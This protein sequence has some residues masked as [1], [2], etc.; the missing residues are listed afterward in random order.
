MEEGLP[1]RIPMILM[2]SVLV[3]E[4]IDTPDPVPLVPPCPS[5]RLCP[6]A[7]RGVTPSRHEA[8]AQLPFRDGTAVVGRTASAAIGA[9]AR[10]PSRHKAWG[11][12]ARGERRDGVDEA[13]KRL[14]RNLHA[15]HR[16]FMENL[17][18]ERKDSRRA[19]TAAAVVIQRYVRGLAVRTRGNPKKYAGI[20]ASLETHYT[21]EELSELL[22]RTIARAGVTVAYV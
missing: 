10:A 18:L 20:R 15:E 5:R 14:A 3:P 19:R 1:F 2:Q 4:Y 6:T 22:D 9:Q 8:R 16:V 21:V 11:F 7:P 12:L 13:K 17:Q